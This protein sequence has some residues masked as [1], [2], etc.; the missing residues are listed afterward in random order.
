MYTLSQYMDD[1]VVLG[2][3]EQELSRLACDEGSGE[4]RIHFDALKDMVD[5]AYGKWSQP[6]WNSCMGM[7]LHLAQTKSINGFE[8][9]RYAELLDGLKRRLKDIKPP[10]RKRTGKK[11]LK[12]DEH[13]RGCACGNLSRFK[14]GLVNL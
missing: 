12:P 11:C 5:M 13:P 3:V 7:M 6:L 2:I 1:K 4:L 10:F 14:E 9:N 8:C